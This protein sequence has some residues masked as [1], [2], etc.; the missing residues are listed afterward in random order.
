MATK[1]IWNLD[2]THSE[3]NFKV[4]HLMISNVKGSF[5]DFSGTIESLDNDF[6]NATVKA[7]IQTASIFT[8]NTDRDNHLKASDFFDAE[9]FPQ[10]TFEGRE[11]KQLDDENYQ[12][13]GALT[14]HGVTKE[15]ALDV[16]FGGIQQDAYGQTKAGFSF[17]GKLNR[18]DFDLTWNALLEAGGVAV[19]EEVKI[20]GEAQF[21]RQAS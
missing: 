8:N 11:F 7:V 2:P 6:S 4:R 20:E 15:I 9:Q 1:T 19:S 17:R 5:R 21:V 13:K 16:E 18:A 12:L 10:I 3:L 14:M